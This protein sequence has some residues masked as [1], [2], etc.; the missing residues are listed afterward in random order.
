MT[1]TKNSQKLIIATVAAVCFTICNSALP[2]DSTL[3]TASQ[4]D[5]EKHDDLQIAY[6]SRGLERRYMGT[7]A[8]LFRKKS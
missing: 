4:Y 7:R 2:Q 5:L 6:R 3:L 8:V 1:R